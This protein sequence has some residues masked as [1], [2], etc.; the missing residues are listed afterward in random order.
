MLVGA[1]IPTCYKLPFWE[2][3]LATWRKVFWGKAW[4][5]QLIRVLIMFFSRFWKTTPP[6]PQK[7]RNF[8]RSSSLEIY[9]STRYF[10]SYLA[11]LSSSSLQHQINSLL[12]TKTD[13]NVTSPSPWPRFDC[14][15]WP[16]CAPQPEPCDAGPCGC[17]LLHRWR[18]ADA[19]VCRARWLMPQVL[20]WIC[21]GVL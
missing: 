8:Q 17:R 16:R 9:W 5:H 13:M 21:G 11:G 12:C 7:K 14:P 10:S 6:P 15:H 3:Q 1:F 18:G 4:S 20:H 19:W 2:G